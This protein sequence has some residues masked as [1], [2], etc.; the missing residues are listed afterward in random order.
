[1]IEKSAFLKAHPEYEKKI[2]RRRRAR[3]NLLMAFCRRGVIIEENMLKVGLGD[4][5]FIDGRPHLLYKGLRR[6]WMK[7]FPKKRGRYQP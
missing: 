4:M 2:Q 1:M 5:C 6:L 3:V 7:L